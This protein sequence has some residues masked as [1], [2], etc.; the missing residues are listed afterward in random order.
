MVCL[1]SSF[2]SAALS[3]VGGNRACAIARMDSGVLDVLHY[4]ADHDGL[5]VGDRVNVDL[6]RALQV[7]IDQ[8]R[9]ALGGLQSL[10][11][12]SPQFLF[13]RN[14]FH[15]APSE[16]VRRPNQHR[17]PDLRRARDRVVE[18]ARQNSLRL[19]QP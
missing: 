12:V 2:C 15:R 3:V 1:I 6:D 14:N 10:R 17:V 7:T 16:H 11:D 13:V 19:L 5:A 4:S 9:M 18:P 8:Q